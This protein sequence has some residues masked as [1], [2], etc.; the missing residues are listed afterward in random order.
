M[1]RI[2]QS[3]KE[4]NV[5][6]ELEQAGDRWRLRFT[7]NLGHSPQKVWEAITQPEQL[8]T[9]FPQ[10]IVGDWKTGAR[11][12]FKSSDAEANFDGEVLAVQ[13]PK[14]LEFKWGTDVLR[15]EITPS[16]S[17]STL[18]LLDTFDELGKAARDGAGWHVCLDALE[19]NLDGTPSD[20]S[21]GES[22][23]EVH[24]DY[25]K[26]FGPEASTIGPPEPRGGTA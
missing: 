6:G 19:R 1:R 25:I 4:A 23:D 17:G 5:N 3:E 14:L 22:W 10:E 8:R 13:P 20:V 18:T 7:R 21:P 16:G 15:F 9:W 12:Q 2:D 26:A 24:E 11:L